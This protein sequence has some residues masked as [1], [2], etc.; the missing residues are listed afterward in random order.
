ME[1]ENHELQ[2]N[3]VKCI[4]VEVVNVEKNSPANNDDKLA[5]DIK[6]RMEMFYDLNG[7]LGFVIGL[8]GFILSMHY[9]NCLPY[10]RYG[11]LFWIWGYVLY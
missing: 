11:S 9:N 5:G 4:N 2:G 10:F 6:F 8:S 3:T 7:S 1:T